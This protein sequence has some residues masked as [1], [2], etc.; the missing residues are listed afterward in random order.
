[1][2]VFMMGRFWPGISEK[3]EQWCLWWSVAPPLLFRSKL[4]HLGIT[5]KIELWDYHW[6]SAQPPNCE[7]AII[8]W[9]WD[10]LRQVQ[11]IRWF[12]QTPLLHKVNYVYLQVSRLRN[13]GVGI[14]FQWDIY[15]QNN[16]EILIGSW[17]FLVLESFL[18]TET[19]CCGYLTPYRVSVTL[20]L[21]YSPWI[22]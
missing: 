5:V 17:S 7:G 4:H 3:F 22:G 2:K 15:H 6:W 10:L 20:L 16:L 12:F 11:Q 14:T 19:S 21:L 8:G 18:M 9:D 13:E 1:M